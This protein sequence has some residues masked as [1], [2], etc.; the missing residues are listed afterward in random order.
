MDNDI[1]AIAEKCSKFQEVYTSELPLLRPY[2]ESFL[3]RDWLDTR[4][5]EERGG[6]VIRECTAVFTV[7]VLSLVIRYERL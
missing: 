4:L 2:I 7:V 3:D 5:A 6:C 1:L